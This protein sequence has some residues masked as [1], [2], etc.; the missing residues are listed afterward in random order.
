MNYIKHLN[1]AFELIYDDDRLLPNHVSLY[2]ALFYQWNL[3]RFVNPIQ[4]NRTEIM[5]ASR[6]RSVTTYTKS[7]K[8][9]HEWGYIQYQPSHNPI[10]GSVVSLSN[11]C[12]TSWISSSPVSGQQ[13]GQVDGK[14]LYSININKHNK[15]YKQENAPEKSDVLIFFKENNW[16][17]TEADKFFC[18]YQANGWVIGNSNTP[19]QDWKAAA[20]K[21]ML[22][23]IQFNRNGKTK[24]N[25]VKPGNLHVEQNKNY[26]EPL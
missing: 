11:F 20:E 24:Q 6:I 14:L 2:M 13:D 19:V 1:R 22:N 21:W 26:S 5:R 16:N 15:I 12:S 8:E 9:L 7:I 10:L 23:S 3:N 25:A 4:I 17:S 18:H